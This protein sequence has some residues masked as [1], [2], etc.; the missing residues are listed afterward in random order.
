MEEL[1]WP[2]L[3]LAVSLVANREFEDVGGLMPFSHGPPFAG[4]CHR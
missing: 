4:Q 3:N 2:R 1:P